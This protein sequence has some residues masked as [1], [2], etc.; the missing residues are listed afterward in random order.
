MVR[1]WFP[2]ADFLQNIED[3]VSPLFP[4]WS[5][6]SSRLP[7]LYE[8]AIRAVTEALKGRTQNATLVLTPVELDEVSVEKIRQSIPDWAKDSLA[9]E[10]LKDILRVLAKRRLIE[11]PLPRVRL[12]TLRRL[13]VDHSA[14]KMM[15]WSEWDDLV[16]FWL[17]TTLSYKPCLT[18]NLQNLEVFTE[19]QNQ[20][21]EFACSAML[22]L[23]I[24]GAAVRHHLGRHFRFLEFKHIDV[25]TGWM[26]LPFSGY[27]RKRETSALRF[28][29]PLGMLAQLFLNRYL[30]FLL[31]WKKEL[32]LPGSPIFPTNYAV[33]IESNFA[34]WLSALAR[35]DRIRL[36]PLWIRKDPCS[37]APQKSSTAIVSKFIYSA[38]AVLLE[39]LPPF[40]VA[41][42]VGQLRYVPTSHA[43]FN[44]LF[45]MDT[46]NGK[47]QDRESTNSVSVNTTCPLPQICHEPEEP[48]QCRDL[49]PPAVANLSS[50][51]ERVIQDVRNYLRPLRKGLPDKA[52]SLIA[53]EIQQSLSLLRVLPANIPESIDAPESN[54]KLFFEHVTDMLCGRKFTRLGKLG[55]A[56]IARYFTGM[57][58]QILLCVGSE[59]LLALRD[60]NQVGK[61]V[62]LSMR[63]YSN[64][65]TQK[66]IKTQ[67]SAFF[68]YLHAKDPAIPEMNPKDP[69]L[70]T[71]WDGHE[72]DLLTY[73]DLNGIIAS[74]HKT[75]EPREAIVYALV[76]TLAGYAGLRLHEICGIRFRDIIITQDQL[77][78]RIHVSKSPAG[79]RTLPL[80]LLLEKTEHILFTDYLVDRFQSVRHLPDW[81][82]LPFLAL[83]DANTRLDEDSL[84]RKAK[85]HLAKAPFDATLHDLRHMFASWL[86][87]RWY[88]ARYGKPANVPALSHRIFDDPCS[89]RLLRLFDQSSI[90]Q[91]VTTDK[92]HD[93]VLYMI[94]RLMGHAFPTTTVETYIHT[95]DLVHNLFLTSSRGARSYLMTQSP[96]NQQLASKMLV[97]D[98]VTANKLIRQATVRG[99]GKYKPL[100]K[101]CN[102]NNILVAQRRRI[103][104]GGR[105]KVT[106]S[107]KKK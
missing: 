39:R 63:D 104:A 73:D 66:A 6:K 53:I 47:H 54:L 64:Q 56:T 77:L 42:L 72:Y 83:D 22:A 93:P 45:L 96:L 91:S 106:R 57:I 80:N 26:T 90:G 1:H 29:I 2:R 7:S 9:T 62:A 69:R 4:A 37:Q 86:L 49:L 23:L 46:L 107:R 34:H 75:E 61:I 18:G 88:V 12:R 79:R 87:V 8:H 74:L 20:H 70:W 41:S 58:D 40:L 25:Q 95:F 35:R 21:H 11:A 102:P 31:K 97:C 28:R 48:E 36:P 60:T 52:L 67:W 105:K 100:G 44:R 84:G 51:V 3:S 30:L 5:R 19:W 38:R 103:K 27:Q 24:D 14:H 98:D 32:G 59:N 65:R 33:H 71:T 76:Y 17:Q 99:G 50:T 94:A 78:L 13:V 92:Y 10:C 81:L 89:E 16:Q 55:P 82:D 101:V 15:Y 68:S 43:S 85:A